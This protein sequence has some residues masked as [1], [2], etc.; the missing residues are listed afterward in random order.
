MRW[1]HRPPR[2][3]VS[4]NLGRP[5]SESAQID[6]K[7]A[8]QNNTEATEKDKATECTEKNLRRFAQGSCYAVHQP[9]IHCL[10]AAARHGHSAVA[11]T[12]FSWDIFQAERARRLRSRRGARSPDRGTMLWKTRALCATLKPE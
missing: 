8:S 7:Q 5:L 3:T 6:L 10:R 2:G 1:L 4:R 12:D 9:L 11:M